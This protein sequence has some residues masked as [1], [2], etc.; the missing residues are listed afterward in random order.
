MGKNRIYRQRITFIGKES[1]FT[2]YFKN[3]RDGR[4]QIII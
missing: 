1:L 2:L 3:N 4:D